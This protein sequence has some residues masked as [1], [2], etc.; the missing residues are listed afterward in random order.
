VTWHPAIDSVTPQDLIRYNIY[1]NTTEAGVFAQAPGKTVIGTAPWI[2]SE[3][4]VETGGEAIYPKAQSF[5]PPFTQIRDAELYMN[6]PAFSPWEVR[7]LT[8]LPNTIVGGEG[9][10]IDL[11][12]LERKTIGLASVPSSKAGWGAFNFSPPLSVTSGLTYYLFIGSHTTTFGI[13]TSRNWAS[14]VG[15]GDPGPYSDG[16]GWIHVD[17][18]N[19]NSNVAPEFE[20]RRDYA[21][22]IRRPSEISTII[23]GLD[24]TP[25]YF[26]GVRAQDEANNEDTNT[27]TIE[28]ATPTPTPIVS[29]IITRVGSYDTPDTAMAVALSGSLVYVADRLAGLQ[30]IDVSDPALPVLRGAHELPEDAAIDVAVSDSM[31]YVANRSAGLQIIDV[32]DPSA[33]FQMG[34]LGGLVERPHVVEKVTVSGVVAY[35]TDFSTLYTIGVWV[36]SAPILAGSFDTP[37]TAWDMAV[38]EPLVYVTDGACGL[39]FLDATELSSPGNR[40]SYDTPGMAQDIALL[41]SLAYVAAGDAGL[42]IIDVSDFGAPVLRGSFDTPGN[43]QAVVVSGSV[44]YVADGG[45]GLQ[46]VDVTD[47]SAPA[48]R[49]FYSTEQDAV[50]L[51][52][53]DPL[54]YVAAGELLILRRAPRP[55]AGVSTW[56]SYE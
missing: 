23:E 15:E 53:S 31:A 10:E 19:D 26:I 46:V 51:A 35:A 12:D 29:E 17:N 37:G 48:L 13:D 30:I 41:G 22:R 44:A 56:G 9:W 34:S 47:P 36:P 42:L 52:V 4:I 14:S 16:A 6:E 7:I 49:S 45:G 28:S 32:S 3:D 18:W 21:F 27:K 20:T 50:D 55:E 2:G 5:R 39:Q 54:I 11:C 43:A 40:G 8:D 24:P 1:W 25:S 33:P 38:D